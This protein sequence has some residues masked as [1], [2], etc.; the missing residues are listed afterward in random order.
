MSQTVSAAV[1]YFGKVPSRG[2]FVRTADNH[3]LMALLDR[4]AGSSIE[5]L[6]Q[7]PDW[8]RLYDEAPDVHYAFMGSR[9]RLVVCGHFL[10]SRD[11][12]QRRFPLLSAIRLE[13]GNPLGFI[14]RSPMALSRVWAGLSRQARSAVVADEAAAPLQELAESRYDLSIEPVAYAAPFADF[15]ELQTIGSLERLLRDSGHPDVVLRR[16]L[17]AL[18]LLLQP[19]LTGSGVT[20]DKGLEL[21]LPRDPLYRPLVGAFWLD[22]V[23]AFVARGDFELAVL[24]RDEDAPRMIVGFNGADQQIL[25]AVLDPQAAA[26]H[27]IRVQ[28]AEWVDDHLPG[29]YA[30]NKLASYVDRHDLS[31]K[32]ARAIFGETFLGA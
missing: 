1:S 26:E 25:R 30:L 24:V 9:S 10:P 19:V 28:D 29:D 12:S 3:Q 18:G 17:P 8:K 23:A 5:L 11:A 20:I 22:I 4:W 31:L 13:V 16:T 15:M 2:D 21:P 32:A 7:N 6:S 14:A 27:L